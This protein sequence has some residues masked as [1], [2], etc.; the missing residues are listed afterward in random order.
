[1]ASTIIIKNGTSGA[2]SSLSAGEFAINT[3]DGGFY[4]GSTGGTSVSSS[5]KF[6]A[7]TASII[8]ASGN[9]EGGSLRADDLTAGRVAFV[10]TDGLLVD[11]SDLTFATATLTA[12]NIAAF[13]L[14]G[15]LTAG[16]TEIEGSAFDINGGNIEGCNITLGSEETL[17]IAEGTLTLA[18]D[19]ISG[20]KIQ[21]GTIGSTT[22]TTLTTAAIEATANIDIGTHSLTANTL[23]SDVATGTPPF[24]VTSTTRVQNLQATT[25]GTIAG[26]APDTATE[27]AT[28]GAITTC[29]N[30]TT[31]GTISSGTWRGTAIELGSGGTGL[32]GATDGKIV[33]ADGSGAPVLLDVGSSTAIETLGTIGT[34]VWQGTTIKTAYIG[35]DQVTE[36][37][38]A[39]TL[40]AEIDANTAKNT[41][42]NIYGDYIKLLPSDF[43]T[44]ADGGNTKYGVGYVQGAG[45]NYGIKVPSPDTE[46]FAFVSIPQGMKAT[47]VEIFGKRAK[48]VEVYEVQI[49]ATTVVSKGTGTCGIGTDSIGDEEFAITNVNATATNLLAIEVTVTSNSADKVY[50]GR[51]KIAAQ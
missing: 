9:V 12:T 7:V 8:S 5:I 11:D 27:E 45:A 46:L 40:L 3:S 26:L 41:S 50:G 22:I 49:N 21:G 36:D 10:G 48:A 24:T 14:T 2:P 17:N 25:V 35:D 33:I 1:M 29:A 42:S 20:D 34:G 23:I 37:K 13:N 44:N 16:S 4:Y 39:D 43:A 38:L 18:N 32:V 47:H 30:L 15:K 31:V 51:V 6:G 19:Q 28:Q